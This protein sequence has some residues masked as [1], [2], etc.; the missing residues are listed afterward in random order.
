ME[1]DHRDTGAAGQR[2]EPGGQRFGVPGAGRP[3]RPRRSR[4]PCGPA[5]VS[6]S[7][8]GRRRAP[9]NAR[10]DSGSATRLRGRAG[11]RIQET[12]LGADTAMFYPNPARSHRRRLAH[13]AWRSRAVPHPASCREPERGR[14]A[15]SR[16][17]SRPP[18]DCMIMAQSYLSVSAAGDDCASARRGRIGRRSTSPGT[19]SRAD[20]VCPVSG[21]ARPPMR[22]EPQ[23]RTSPATISERET[24]PEDP[25]RSVG[26]ARPQLSEPDHLRLLPHLWVAVPR[27]RSGAEDPGSPAGPGPLPAAATT[28]SSSW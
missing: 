12:L 27:P 2:L 1:T 22:T 14:C 18:R 5:R 6:P 28:I 25:A 8:A 20:W 26:S 19:S 4:S 24:C 16:V 17:D 15:R 23:H 7:A 21:C 10:R 9:L 3:R 13:P 11:R